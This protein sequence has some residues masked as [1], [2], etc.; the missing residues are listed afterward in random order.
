MQ[1]CSER[2][3]LSMCDGVYGVKVKEREELG[4]PSS[5]LSSGCLIDDQVHRLRRPER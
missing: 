3:D 5:Q 1:L 2:R 4:S